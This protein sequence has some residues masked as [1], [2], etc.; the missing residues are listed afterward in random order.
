MNKKPFADSSSFS[1]FEAE[2]INHHHEQTGSS[3]ALCVKG[4]GLDEAS[5]GSVGC[6]L[7]SFTNENQQGSTHSPPPKQVA[8]FLT[9]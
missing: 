6:Q 9:S 5:G 4:Q 1:H 3:F 8:L 2:E 7:L